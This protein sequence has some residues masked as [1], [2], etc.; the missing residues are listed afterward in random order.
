[1]RLVNIASK[2]R[3]LFL[4]FRNEEGKLSIVEE[5][6]FY[7]YYYM[8]SP[9][10]KSI[11]FDGIP[12]KKALCTDPKEMRKL[13]PKLCYESDVHFTKRYLLDKIDTITPTKIKYCF[14]DIEVLT[15]GFP[16]IKKAECPVSCI[17]IYNSD[18]KKVKT[19]YLG[20]Y[21]DNRKTEEDLIND[22]VAYMNKEKFDI[23]L[24][25]NT[26]FDYPYL[27]NRYKS[28]FGKKA[29][30][31]MDISPVKLSRWAEWGTLMNKNDNKDI[32]GVWFPA[33][34]SVVDMMQWYQK[35]TLNKRKS[36]ALDY[37]AQV[38]LKEES[39]GKED[40]FSTLNTHT[41][42]KNI[43][44][45]VR[46]AKL[47]EMTGIIAYFDEIRRL[48]KVEWEDLYHNSRTLD[49]LCLQ[50]A[51]K[52]KVVLPSKRFNEKEKYEGA[53]RQAYETG[54]FNDIG[55]VDLGSAY[56]TMIKDFCLD[57]TNIVN[58]TGSDV[59]DIS[60]DTYDLDIDGDIQVDEE[61]NKIM[62]RVDYHFRQNPEAVLPTVVRE[63][64]E[65]KDRIKKEKAKLIPDSP[66][67]KLMSVKYD[68]I[69]TI[70]NSAY[71]VMGNRFFRL[72]DK[73]IAETITFLVRDVLKYSEKRL[74]EDGNKVIYV[75]TDSV[76]YNSKEDKSEILNDYIQDW[77]FQYCNDGVTLTFDYE[78]Y[79]SE[80]IILA[81][82]RYKGW[83]QTKKGEKEETKGIEA[84]RNDSTE[85]MK[86]FQVS[87][88]DKLRHKTSEAE[89]IQW[90]RNEK[91]RIKSL[92]LEQV[93]FPCKLGRKPEDYVN[94]PIWVRALEASP[95][96]K[97]LGDL[98]YYTYI[99]PQKI[100]MEDK[101]TYYLNTYKLSEKT[102]EKMEDEFIAGKEKVLYRR[103]EYTKAEFEKGIKIEKVP[104][105][106]TTNVMAFDLEKKDHVKEVNWDLMI[107]RNILNKCQVI[108]EAMGWDLKEV[109]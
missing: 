26:K 9:D 99:K 57:P 81:K 20:D 46:M 60:F 75:D 32:D 97:R 38:D 77:A 27:Y 76:F 3:D 42:D 100:G 108:F 47:E 94:V 61:G 23:W 89:M 12:L 82:C 37:I 72:Y 95:I 58:K 5:N 50:E 33:G 90:I 63:L 49:M 31:A 87:F 24:S 7:P 1:M 55:K 68:S 74:A 28:L 13:N 109:M 93:A 4:F 107:K 53:H 44:D 25:W 43:N 86:S 41:R 103:K 105:E 36:Y 45:V 64:M 39:W 66:E 83:L 80:L 10:G 84:K 96:S 102:Y 71:G 104:V 29:D 22:F 91:E 65:I 56:P 59:I 14:L 40:D 6:G 52:R 21:A 79:Y 78:G 92:P 88:L 8:E 106:V 69:K 30:F 35:Y 54:V 67:E 11:S 101:E 15:S 73:R 17:S 2:K 16:S 48:A 98:Y 62:K 34:L 85:F 70:V 19:F 51:I 18:D